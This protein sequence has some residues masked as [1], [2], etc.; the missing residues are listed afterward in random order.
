MH[1]LKFVGGTTEI[2]NVSYELT[3]TEE[4]INRILGDAIRSATQKR[5]YRAGVAP[6]VRNSS[7]TN[8]IIR[9]PVV[10]KDEDKDIVFVN[11]NQLLWWKIEKS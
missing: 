1:M 3:C 11:L 4:E 5:V 6:V 2:E 8:G 9:L 10:Y 7:Y